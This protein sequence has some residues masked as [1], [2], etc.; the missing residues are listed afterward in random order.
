MKQRR[1]LLRE[2]RV[3]VLAERRSARPGERRLEQTV[4]A[5]LRLTAE[6]PSCDPQQVL[7]IE[8]DHSPRR[9]SASAYGGSSSSSTS[10]SSSRRLVRSMYSRTAVRATSCIERPSR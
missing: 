10:S 2:V 1:R 6:G 7:E 9:R 8:E 3:R 5:H 4:I